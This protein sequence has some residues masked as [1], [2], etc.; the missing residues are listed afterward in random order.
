M[1]YLAGFFL[2]PMVVCPVPGDYSITEYK[3]GLLMQIFYLLIVF[4]L[5]SCGLRPIP[6]E[7][8]T[9]TQPA[10]VFATATLI[11][12]FTPR[13]SATIAPPTVAPTIAPVQAVLTSQVNVRSGPGVQ[14]ASLGL[15]GLGTQ[16]QVTGRNPAGTWWQIIYPA[17]STTFGWV[18]AAYMQIPASDSGKI[19]I[20]LLDTGQGPDPTLP[21]S[22]PIR[23]STP[24]LPPPSQERTARVAKEMF[25]R[26]GPGQVYESQGTVTAGSTL[27]LTGRTTNN[28]WV[29]IQYVSN[30]QGVG[31]V[32][33][34]FLENVNLEELPYYDNQGNLLVDATPIP[35]GGAA[36]LTP[37]AFSPA[38]AD[39][40][41][42]SNPAV[43]VEFSPEGERQIEYTS[44]LSS[45]NGDDTD[46][47]SFTP[48]DPENGATFVYLKLECSGNGAVTG[49]LKKDGIV[50]PETEPLQCGNYD[51]AMRVLGGQEYFLVLS[52]DGSGGPLR[53]VN[54]RVTIESEP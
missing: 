33:S 30:S 9:P 38:A 28:V 19:P 51:F 21:F 34:A 24:T 29:R 32:A 26:V 10:L 35:N 2:K 54:Y 14:E 16:V 17:G 52:A 8:S 27:V 7:T 31:W 41:S 23:Q 12:T 46:W 39:G 40:D 6:S 44:D 20:V 53:Y 15:L 47:I 3:S 25:V 43:R 45:P 13:P 1:P 49:L 36:T 50:V 11:P 5:A 4:L 37:T 48:Y 18:T 22:Q 42:E